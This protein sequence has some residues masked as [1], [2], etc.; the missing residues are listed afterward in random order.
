MAP[1]GF[2]LHS[3][4]N[5]DFRVCREYVRAAIGATDDQPNASISSQQILQNDKSRSEAAI[6]IWDDGSDPHGTLVEKYLNSRAHGDRALRSSSGRASR[7]PALPR[8][9]QPGFR[10]PRGP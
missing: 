5:D 2:V 10:P 1:D 8:P 7:A 3:F 4:A 6:R 9:M